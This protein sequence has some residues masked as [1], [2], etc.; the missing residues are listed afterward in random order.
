[1]NRQEILLKNYIL[2]EIYNIEK[3]E[4]LE[5]GR[6]LDWIK[7][8]FDDVKGIFAEDKKLL[9]FYR[10]KQIERKKIGDKEGL[11]DWKQAEEAH[12]DIKAGNRMKLTVG[13]ALLFVL[14]NLI[15]LGGTISDVPSE[16]IDDTLNRQ[17][18]A[19]VIKHVKSNPVMSPKEIARSVAILTGT[20]ADDLEQPVPASKNYDQYRRYIDTGKRSYDFG[21]INQS[22]YE[23][24]LEWMKYGNPRP[25]NMSEDEH[26]KYFMEMMSQ[27]K[28]D[29]FRKKQA[30]RDNAERKLNRQESQKLG[31]ILG[32]NDFEK[33]DILDLS[34]DE[35]VNHAISITEKFNE[36][37]EDFIKKYIRDYMNS[38]VSDIDKSSVQLRMYMRKVHDNL[39]KGEA[40]NAL[41]KVMADVTL[42]DDVATL[43]QA[44]SSYED[45]MSH[46]E[47]VSQENKGHIETALEDYYVD[48]N[49]DDDNDDY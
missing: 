17:E 42:F 4:L 8:K 40:Q 18:I 48:A 31:N 10:K 47:D 37:G 43:I 25:S 13:S 24:Y 7:D 46:I 29:E 1:M 12:I 16:K 14:S 36:S 11:E 49:N 26:L 34:E 22:T 15:P 2:S 38:E 19:D 28:V 27:K 5:E 41:D 9:D 3:K 33:L 6:I 23:K 45:I 30:E 35:L 44:K 39:P 21:I 32:D 20:D